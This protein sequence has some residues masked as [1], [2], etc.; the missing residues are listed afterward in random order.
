MEMHLLEKHEAHANQHGPGVLA[1][2]QVE[3]A[4]STMQIISG[5]RRQHL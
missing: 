5:D 4:C 1:I 3:E 2:E